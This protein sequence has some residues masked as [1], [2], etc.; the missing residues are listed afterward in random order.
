[1]MAELVKMVCPQKQWFPDCLCDTGFKNVGENS[2]YSLSS[3]SFV[4]YT[5]PSYIL[6]DTF[7][8]FTYA[9]L[10]FPK[11]VFGKG[12]GILI[13]KIVSVWFPLHTVAQWCKACS[14]TEELCHQG[15]DTYSP[16]GPSTLLTQKLPC[17]TQPTGLLWRW[18]KKRHIGHWEPFLLPR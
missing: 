6:V 4:L 18:H 9:C 5:Q 7:T 16:W 17:P 13:F 15:Q 1:M 10:I 3:F 2:K 11:F 14:A 12:K 8:H